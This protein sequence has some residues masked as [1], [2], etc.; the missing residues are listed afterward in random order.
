MLL[1]AIQTIMVILYFVFCLLDL[2]P[3]WA[4]SQHTECRLSWHLQTLHHIC[5]SCDWGQ[6]SG[7]GR[8]CGRVCGAHDQQWEHPEKF[9]W[10]GQH[11]ATT[12][13]SSAQ[14]SATV[15]LWCDGLPCSGDK[16]VLLGLP[17][18][19]DDLQFV[20]RILYISHFSSLYMC[21]L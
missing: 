19:S 3:H 16:V 14:Y 12:L 18:D 15:L 9:K 8:A 7:W 20:R 5:W 17:Q 10:G 1:G 4:Q 11:V 21:V 6:S 13:V 2:W